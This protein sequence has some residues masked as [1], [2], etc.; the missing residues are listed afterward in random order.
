MR[1]HSKGLLSRPSNPTFR[2][3]FEWTSNE[4]LGFDNEVALTTGDGAIEPPAGCKNVQYPDS[5]FRGNDDARTG[6][7]PD[8]ARY[9][10]NRNS[11][12]FISSQPSFSAP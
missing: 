11:S 4:A 5:R 10:T 1:P 9:R 8:S 6:I 2:R 7:S 3:H 12:K